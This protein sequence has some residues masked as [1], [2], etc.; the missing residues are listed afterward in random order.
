[1]GNPLEDLVN[2]SKVEQLSFWLSRFVVEVHR[3]DGKPY[4][5]ATIDILA[6]GHYRYAKRKARAPS[7]EV[8]YLIL[9]TQ[10]IQVDGGDLC[11]KD[12]RDFC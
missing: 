11:S 5:P 10:E 2:S 4:L 12:G 3:G 9:W 1:M 6:V 8:V 7:D